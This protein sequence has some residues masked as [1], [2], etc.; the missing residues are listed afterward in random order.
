MPTIQGSFTIF[1]TIDWIVFFSA[2]F[3]FP[4]VTWQLNFYLGTTLAFLRTSFRASVAAVQNFRAAAGAVAVN[5]GIFVTFHKI[6][7]STRENFYDLPLAFESRQD[8]VWVNA[9]P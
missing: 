9:A 2:Q 6:V 5:H 8:V 3:L 7:V 1:V 4:V